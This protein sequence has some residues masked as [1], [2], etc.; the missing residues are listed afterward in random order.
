MTYKATL[1]NYCRC[2]DSGAPKKKVRYK[3]KKYILVKPAGCIVLN[4][5]LPGQ[6]SM[7]GGLKN[8]GFKMAAVLIGRNV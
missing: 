5:G 2:S 3:N 8:Y 6:S 7:F 1:S 4:R